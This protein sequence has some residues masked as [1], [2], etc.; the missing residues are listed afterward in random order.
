MPRRTAISILAVGAALLSL[1]GCMTPR[2][3]TK[4]ELSSVEQQCGLSAGELVQDEELK[5]VV[6]LFRVGPTPAERSCVYRWAHKN[7]LHLAV[8]DA[9]NWTDK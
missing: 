4:Q 6:V 8:I 1:S 2:M 3:H 5:K 9:V 7:H